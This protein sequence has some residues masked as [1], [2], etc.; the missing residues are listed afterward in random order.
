[1]L[2]KLVKYTSL[3][4]ISL[5]ITGCGKT[6]HGKYI[7]TVL[8]EEPT[9]EFKV[10]KVVVL[11]AKNEERREKEGWFYKFYI[12]E[13]GKQTR[14]FRL[15]AKVVNK[16]AFYLEE[17]LDDKIK[18]HAYFDTEPAYETVKDRVVALIKA[19]E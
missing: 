15:V 18:S 2:S 14:M 10:G 17:K 11:A 1:M 4:L 19:G 16:R 12:Y 6:Y 3:V 13:D 7:T 8:D 9:D 5:F